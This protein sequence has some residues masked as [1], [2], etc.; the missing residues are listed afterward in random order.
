MGILVHTGEGRSC[1]LAAHCLV[2]R[3]S[4]CTLRLDDAWVSSEHASVSWRDERWEVRDLGS[5]NGTFVNGTQIP[6]GGVVV[7]AA[8]DEI[9]FGDLASCYRLVDA[10]PPV[11][12]VR[13]LD[14]GETVPA[15]GNML[16]L[17][18]EDAPLLC[19]IE[20]VDGNWAAESQGELRAVQDGEIVTVAGVPYMLHL[21]VQHESTLTMRDRMLRVKDVELRFR[22]SRDE[23]HVELLLTARGAVRQVPPRAHHYTFL[24]LARQRLRDAGTTTPAPLAGWL[25]VDELCRML[26][27]DQNRLNVDICRIRRDVA[28][29]AVYDAAGVIERQRG[30]VR[31]GTAKIIIEHRD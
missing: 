9:A 26:A 28:G 18:S 12:T 16:V 10:S 22:V 23:E 19:V 13:R 17:P 2:G 24:T 25:R 20:D 6:R 11:A 30:Q 31:V 14:T 3:A 21:P 5:R 29:L 15:Q 8:G 4:T 7:L 27:V 1:A